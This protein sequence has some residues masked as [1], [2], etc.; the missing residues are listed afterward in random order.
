MN[1]PEL[2]KAL[3]IRVPIGD[4]IDRITILE[5]KQELMGNERQLANVLNELES[6]RTD[7]TSSGIHVEGE[8]VRSLRD[9]N[10]AIFLLMDKVFQL[11]QVDLQYASVAKETVDL[12][13]TR[14]KLKREINLLS[15]SALIEEK[16]FFEEV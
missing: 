2:G 14:A 11:A 5:V 12:N 10:R 3:L 9:V 15:E 16:T 7:L 1:A 13:M 4:V 6:L 8:L